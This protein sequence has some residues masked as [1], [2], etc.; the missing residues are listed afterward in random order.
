MSAGADSSAGDNAIGAQE[1]AIP[2]CMQARSVG[3]FN[4]GMLAEVGLIP[5]RI[6]NLIRCME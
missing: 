1:G 5:P 6:S 4:L 3:A 2:T